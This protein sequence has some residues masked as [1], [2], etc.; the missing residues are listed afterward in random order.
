MTDTLVRNAAVESALITR[1]TAADST[2]TRNL[3]ETR[4]TPPR[5]TT[6]VGGIRSV[7]RGL[8]DDVDD[9][10]KRTHD[11]KWRTAAAERGKASV[12]SLLTELADLGFA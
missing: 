12:T 3:T 7:A 1:A 11:D 5:L 8:H 4:L 2:F 6:E 9:L 10:H